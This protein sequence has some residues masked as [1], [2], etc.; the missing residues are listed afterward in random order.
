VCSG[1]GAV[2]DVL[3]YVHPLLLAPHNGMKF[4]TYDVDND[5]NDDSCGVNWGG[6][7]WYNNCGAISPTNVV[8]VWYNLGSNTWPLMKNVRMMTMLQ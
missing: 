1:A 3:N 2:Y 5:V 4:T 6:G 8:M 7:F